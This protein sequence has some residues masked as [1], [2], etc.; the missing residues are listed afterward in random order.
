MKKTLSVM[1]A[2][3]FAAVLLPVAAQAAEGGAEPSGDAAMPPYVQDEA[4]LLTDGQRLS[5]EN[6]AEAIYEK[7]QCEVRIFTIDDMYRLDIAYAHDGD[8]ALAFNRLVYANTDPGYGGGRSC[9]ILCLSMAERDYWLEVYGPAMTA[10]TKYG[11]DNMLDGYV[12]PKLSGDQ[13]YEAFSA[14]LGR[15]E[16]F[17]EMAQNGAPFD[18]ATDPARKKTALVIKLLATILLPLLI[19]AIVC[20]VWKKQMK[21]AVTARSADNYIPQGG[22]RLTGQTD[23]FLY[24]A[25]TRQKIESSSS[26]SSSGSRSDSGGSQGRGGKF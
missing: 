26:S 19:A 10:F 8:D 3:L 17:L 11:I 25:T 18:R 12:L 1:L 13:Y 15:G 5:L 9:V 7:Y 6:R 2:V 21:T 22:F 23:T 4:G 24:R 16:E 20:A 14:Y